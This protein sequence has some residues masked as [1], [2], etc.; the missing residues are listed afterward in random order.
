[1]PQQRRDHAP[2]PT[3]LLEEQ[4]T[5]TVSNF[6]LECGH[7]FL[8]CPVAYK[9]FGTLND[10]HDNVMLICHALTGSADVSD[11]W[12]PLLG[13]G[14][15]FDTDVFYVV[16]LNVLGSPYGTASP[17]TCPSPDSVPYASDF[18]VCSIRDSV[19]LHYRVLREHLN[20]W[21]V[22]VAIGG[23]M[24]GMQV[25][26]WSLLYPTFVKLIV[27]IATCARQ[28]AWCISWS[29]AQRQTIYSDPWFMRGKYS[30]DRPPRNGLAVAR[31]QALLT[32]RTRNS[33][34]SKFSRQACS[35]MISRFS[36]HDPGDQI[37]TAQ[38]YLRYQGD[39]FLKRF[40]ANCY[41]SITRSMD[42]HDISRDTDQ[43][44]FER[45]ASISQPAL[46]IGIDSDGLFPR[47]EQQEIHDHLVNSELHIIHSEQGHDGFL[48]EFQ[49]ISKLLGEW[50]QK[51]LPDD[52]RAIYTES[53][54]RVRSPLNMSPLK[55]TSK[56]IVGEVDD[57]Q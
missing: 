20:I 41:I 30:R 55:V 16:C 57:F 12:G 51:S 48:L 33:F 38:S 4:H 53:Q 10:A 21:Q 29:E 56:S 47:N 32:Y 54:S 17:L 18:P 23:S 1:M 46:V 19:N 13:A 9:T 15:V 31:M 44:C 42:T 24:G 39:K 43:T 50:L 37:F 11:W 45:L 7:V 14:K 40:D 6:T 26:E 36:E 22:Q 28:S 34:E 52:F 2:L 8:N 27:P 35:A 49:E 5:A 25:L 3:A